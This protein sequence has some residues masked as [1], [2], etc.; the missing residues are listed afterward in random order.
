MYMVAVPHDKC[1]GL[2]G[3]LCTEVKKVVLLHRG[4]RSEFLEDGY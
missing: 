3:V 2:G 4:D 1:R